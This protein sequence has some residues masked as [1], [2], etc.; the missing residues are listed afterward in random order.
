MAIKK[1]KSKEKKDIQKKDFKKS[2]KKKQS[3]QIKWII[4]LMVIMILIIVIVPMI[5]KNF[6]DRFVYVGL[7]FQKTKLGELTFY[8]T[9]IPVANNQDQVI[10]TYSMNFRSDP[11]K[12]GEIDIK[13]PNNNV[14][15]KKDEPNYISLDLDMENCEYTTIALVNLANFLRGFGN[16]TVGSAFND[17]NY[18]YTEGMVF[19]DCLNTYDNTVILVQSGDENKIERVNMNCYELTFKDCEIIPVTEKLTLIILENYMEYFTRKDVSLHKKI[20]GWFS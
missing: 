6:V 3:F 2:L 5:K 14:I 11:R 13:M 18:A 10:G 20:L 8:S 16:L 4:A 12:L 19:R 9:R 7:D 15:F 1:E 17:K